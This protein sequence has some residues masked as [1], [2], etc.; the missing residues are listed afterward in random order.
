MQAVILVG[1]AAGVMRLLV[2]PLW[3]AKRVRSVLP[4]AL[5]PTRTPTRT[6]PAT[7]PAAAP[8]TKLVLRTFAGWFAGQGLETV[9]RAEDGHPVGLRNLHNRIQIDPPKQRSIYGL[10][11]DLWR[12]SA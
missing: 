3:S 9:L 10:A 11:M 6:G 4:G 7:A 1:I 12:W 8:D 2:G 5:I